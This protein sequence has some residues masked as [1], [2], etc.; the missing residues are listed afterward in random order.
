MAIPIPEINY[1]K[2]QQPEKHKVEEGRPEKTEMQDGQV[3]YR[4]RKGKIHMYVK[5]DGETFNVKLDRK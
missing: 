5:H 2:K 4:M 1:E 3:Q